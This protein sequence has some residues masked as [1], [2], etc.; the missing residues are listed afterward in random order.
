MIE[1][2]H[3]SNLQQR[4]FAVSE[5]QI[6]WGPL[7]KNRADSEESCT[8]QKWEIAESLSTM[9]L[10]YADDDGIVILL[11]EVLLAPDDVTSKSVFR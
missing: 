1:L 4:P 10:K 3:P 7:C 9:V 11:V 2:G 8:R 6:I 5:I